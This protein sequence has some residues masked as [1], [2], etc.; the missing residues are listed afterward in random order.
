MLLSDH[1]H[2]L[3]LQPVQYQFPTGRGDV[4]D[5]NWLVVS[6]R[7]STPEGRW[8]FLDACLLT[9]EAAQLTEWLRRVAAGRV[10]VTGPDRTGELVPNLSFLEPLLGFG[11]ARWDG[12]AGAV[13]VHLKAEAVPRSS[14]PNDENDF[15]MEIEVDRAGLLAAAEEW[16]LA[17]ARYPG[18]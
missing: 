3:E 14:D 16:E 2:R 11:L 13:R 8:R 4:W 15:L 9:D 1:R 7:V 18:R 6:G 17:C 10:P 5:D 12:D